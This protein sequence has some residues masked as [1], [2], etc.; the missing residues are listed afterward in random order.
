MSPPDL[1]T[2]WRLCNER[3]AESAFEGIG[4]KRVG[5]RWN[6]RGTPIGYTSESLAL[7]ALE[8]LVHVRAEDVPDDL[9]AI[10]A[11]VPR[12]LIIEPFVDEK[13]DVQKEALPEGWRSVSGNAA[14][15]ARGD[16]WQQSGVSAAM[17]VPSVVIPEEFNVLLN[18]EHP[19]FAL[20]EIG[21]PR[22]FSFDSR[23]FA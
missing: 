14:V 17:Q 8:L 23:L 15:V 22:P 13:S 16:Q 19:D 6:S 5:G 7:A 11:R 3:Y 18:P 4:A 10:F 12:H 20:I 21:E 1:L 9:I 2:V